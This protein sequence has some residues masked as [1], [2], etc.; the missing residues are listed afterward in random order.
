MALH[1]RKAILGLRKIK[2]N[3]QQEKWLADSGISLH[4][5]NQ[6]FDYS[7][8]GGIESWWKKLL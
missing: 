7:L 8:H 1:E 4:P 2:S 5:F 6:K 3:L